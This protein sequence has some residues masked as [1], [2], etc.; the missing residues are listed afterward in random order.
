VEAEAEAPDHG[1]WAD[2]VPAAGELVEAAEGLEVE[3]EKTESPDRKDDPGRSL[4][5]RVSC[6]GIRVCRDEHHDRS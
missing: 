2:N 4:S 1:Y 3:G 6:R 5:S